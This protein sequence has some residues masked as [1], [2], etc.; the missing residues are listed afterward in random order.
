MERARGLFG[1]NDDDDDIDVG[2][3]GGG[4]GGGGLFNGINDGG[5]GGAGDRCAGITAGVIK[6]T[7]AS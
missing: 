3:G 2:G 6:L 1:D 5:A 4:G 7:L